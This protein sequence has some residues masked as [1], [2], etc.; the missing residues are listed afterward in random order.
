MNRI[1]LFVIFL[2]TVLLPAQ[3]LSG[4]ITNKSG[5][6]L[7]EVYVYN[8]ITAS[9][10]HSNESGRFVIENT[11]KNDTLKIGLLGYKSLYYVVSDISTAINL[12][13]E[14][15]IFGLSEVYVQQKVNALSVVADI[16]LVTD[17][18]NSSQE[19]LRV[20][21]GLFIGQH[22][23]GGKA[24]QIFLRGF[25]IDHGTD[26]NLSVDG[27]PVNMVS[28]AHGQGYS[29]LHFIIPETVDKV[30]FGKGSYYAD[31]G[32]FTTAG[33]VAFK[34]K[35]NLETSNIGIEA[36][37]FNTFRMLGMF[38][39]LDQ[40]K[41]KAYFATEYIST[42]GP[43]DS[44]QNFR[45]F[46]AMGKYTSFLNDNSKLSLSASHFNSTWDASGQIPQRAVDAGL[47]GRFGAIDDTEG[48]TTRRTNINLHYNKYINDNTIL[49][50]NTFYTNYQFELYSNFT[51][52]LED[53]DNGDQ[54]KQKENRNIFGLN[55]ELNKKLGA[56]ISLDAGL[57]FRN[58]VIEDNELSHT[59]N[60]KST[61]NTIQL[62]DVDETNFYGFLNAEFDFGKLTI[63]PAVRIDHFKFI[64]NDLLSDTYRTLSENKTR[65]SPKLNFI[66]AQNE[67]LQFYLKTGMGFHS[68]DT[69]VVVAQ[70]GKEILPV[71]YGA[72]LGTIWKPIPR[73]FINGALWYLFLEQEFVY[74]GD[75]GIV[76]PSG[77][78][79]RMGA[80]LGV[81]YQLTDWLFL[82]S[83]ITYTYARSTEEPEGEDYIPLA[84]D[85][86]YTGGLSTKFD[87][88]FSAGLQL[89]HLANRP[90][91]EDN[92]IVA[93][94]YTVTDINLNYEWK[95]I[96]FGITVENLFD[97]EWN[98]T[99]FA[100][101]SRLQDE[102]TPV[103]EIHFTPGMPFFLKGRIVF[104]I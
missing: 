95:N 7:S 35:E 29:D 42:D 67:D 62:G 2:N 70:N 21:P 104:K 38:N 43:Y 72:D 102:Q 44:P 66:Y 25:D 14:E 77:K 32:N 52:F 20:V 12:R 41:N 82:D 96:L 68:N 64:Y 28:H 6:P 92:S 46:N 13:L 59:L 56:N 22:A 16:D 71:S 11:H 51:F 90:A 99:Q 23:G 26:L 40:N 83:D 81:R 53:P 87:S 100:T 1:I 47:I 33:Y 69:R 39:V 37:Q 34:T 84:P 98:E 31:K 54:I 94:G 10:A 48:G 3:T 65:I 57:G 79:R 103:E 93:K 80:D 17:P 24:E 75:A 86:T 5:T 30:D 27:M 101:E 19:I 9:H 8:T 60:R 45:R 91:N 88:G 36:G 50:A 85:F 49:K 4:T 58:D 61:L 78:T 97:T 15:Q 55:V 76:E 63:N 74:V 73:L 18:V 89:R